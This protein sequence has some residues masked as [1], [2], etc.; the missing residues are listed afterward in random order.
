[1]KLLNF[2]V[3]RVNSVQIG[4]QMVRTAHVKAP[5]N[6]P[7]VITQNGAAGDER[8]AH[9]DKIYAFARTAYDYWAEYLGRDRAGWPDGFFG[10]NLT[11][12]T[13]DELDVRIGDIFTVGDEVKL[14][15]TGARTPCV[16]LAWR[17]NQPRTFQKI[18]A[19]SRHTGVYFGVLAAG[20]VH[21]GDAVHRIRHD[22]TMPSV[23]E[24]CD[25]VASHHPLPLAPLQ[26]L[27][28]FEQLS[29]ALRFL[30]G[31]KLDAAERAATIT[32]GRWPGWRPF[33]V[34]R[35]VQEAPDIAS[36][37][38]RPT[39]GARICQPRPGQFVSVRMTAADGHAI[40]RTWSLSAFAYDMESYRLTVRR[41]GGIGSNWFHQALTGDAVL[42]RAPA[43]KFVLDTGGF[44]P[45]VLIAGGIGIT[46]LFAML[47]AH[48]TRPDA[49]SMHLFYG[50]RTPT[51]AAFREELAKLAATYP[52]LRV[53]YAYSRFA[54]S[55]QAAGRITSDL[56]VGGLSDLHV[57]VDGHR[58][59]LPWYEN[60]TYL[61]GPGEF[62]RQLRDELVARGANPDHVFSES[63][64]SA[65]LSSSLPE[66]SEVRF[67]HSKVTSVWKASEDLSLLELAEQAGLALPNDCRAGSCLTCRTRI[68][69][70]E[71]TA[72]V[73]DGTALLCV[74]R[75]KSTQV[76]LDC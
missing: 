74:G 24:V 64:A 33:V 75:P 23:A 20:V 43:G 26:R 31:A 46:P 15:V 57:T 51:H 56:I 50:A 60:D 2:S 68:E 45:V 49:P 16:K 7:W 21:S 17:L 69:V 70:G 11:F 35:I 41:Q 30:L 48:L 40:T 66:Q 5:V 54:T 9:P 55:E 8:A 22:P 3:G 32:A 27:L 58:I 67:S 61:C 28:E 18:F 71:T 42:L 14:V 29:P 13:L 59:A 73:G 39:D 1:V 47:Q 4:D 62:C 76:T 19:K 10:E 38:L 25:F 6:G 37:E 52:H 34:S 36:F 72:D 12:D 53:T 44:R 63:F 65:E